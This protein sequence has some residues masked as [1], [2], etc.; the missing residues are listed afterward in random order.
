MDQR[1]VVVGVDG[2]PSSWRALE[3]AAEFGHRYQVPVHGLTTWLRP[4]TYGPPVV[5][6]GEQRAALER[7]DVEAMKQPA[8]DVLEEAI[9]GALGPDAQVVRL[10]EE[11]HPAAVLVAASESARLLVM[12][13]RGLGT[14]R[15]MLLGSVSQHCVIHARCPVL[16]I[17]DEA[18][19][20]KKK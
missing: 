16:V 19:D 18:T 15:G 3:W 9:V 6:T 12:G 8:R 13:S 20:K 5:H 11:G 17:P 10:V 4:A 14:V 1:P 7:R 2:S